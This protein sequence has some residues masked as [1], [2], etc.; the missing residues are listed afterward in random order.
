MS[1]SKNINHGR[2]LTIKIVVRQYYWR[3]YKKPDIKTQS[4]LLQRQSR[5]RH[6]S[7]Q[8][9]LTLSFYAKGSGN[10]SF[11]GLLV[12]LCHNWY[13]KVGVDSTL[14]KFLLVSKAMYIDL[15]HT[16]KALQGYLLGNPHSL[17]N[18]SSAWQMAAKVSQDG[19][20]TEPNSFHL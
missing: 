4:S 5:T 19:P 8:I 1:F 18:W 15:T 10:F 7:H 16:I 2:I 13:T 20:E 6:F 12:L 17:R 14:S 3:E 11:V 9:T